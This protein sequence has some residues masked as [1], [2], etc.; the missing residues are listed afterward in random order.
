M[1]FSLFYVL[2]T[3]METIP[4]PQLQLA[5]D[6]V[7]FTGSNIFL[8]GK[9]GTGKTTFLHNLRA[10][11][12]KRLIVVAPTGVAAIN[13]GGVTIHSFFQLPFGP[14]IPSEPTGNDASRETNNPASQH[15]QRFSR[16]KINIIKSLDLLVIDEIS[17]VRADLLDG[18]D[19]V[20]RR[21]KDRYKPFGGVQLLMIGDLQQL[22][23]VI[24]DDEWEILKTYYDTGF[25]F[26]SKA[27]QKTSYVSIELKHIYRQSDSAFIE[28][29]NKVRENNLDA[30]TL[31][32]LNKRHIPDFA[33]SAGE[34]YITLTTHN[35]Q[36]QELNESKLQKLP[37]EPQTFTALVQGEFPEY[38]YP[39]D[40]ELTLKADAQVMFV[41]NDSSREKLYYNGK[42]GKIVSFDDD[43]IYVKCPGEEAEIPVQKAEWQNMKYSID[44][45]T[46]EIQ[47]TVAGSFVQYPL[48][49]AWAITIHKSQ[50]LTFERAI[51]DARSA[52][53]HGQVYVA[54]SRCKTM[55][56]LVLSTPISY[57]SIKSDSTVSQFN[58]NVEENQPTQQKLDDSKYD[59]QQ[60][61]LTELFEFATLQQR[62]NYCL[63]LS[64]EHKASIHLS[65]I[66]AFNRMND[67]LK[68]EMI[69]VS[70]KFKA[71]VQQLVREHHDLEDNEALQDRVKKACIYFADKVETS[72][73]QVIQN[74]SMDIDNKTVRKSIND[75]VNRLREDIVIKLACLKACQNGFVVKDY[76]EARAKS[77]IEKAESR[78]V[79]KTSEELNPD[80]SGKSL[81]YARLKDWREEK[82]DEEDLPLYMI[83]PQ[84]TLMDVIHYMPVSAAELLEIKGFG[85][86]KVKSFGQEII[87]IITEY[88]NEN[89]IEISKERTERLEPIDESG[90]PEK[91][92]KPDTKQT[93]FELFKAGKKVEE[94][95]TERDMAL[96]TIEG[97]LA[98][99]VGT[100][101]LD[102]HQ[103]VSDEKIT[104]ISGYFAR[105][106]GYNLGPAKASLGDNVSWG[107]LR[108]VLKYLEYERAGEKLS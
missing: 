85:K 80:L 79:K 30:Q 24:K 100:G 93:S 31:E 103:F 36:A 92:K 17:M 3:I 62:L 98:H 73:F 101:E 67:A 20:L 81:L 57:Q 83:L 9:A 77:A 27:L 15:I 94:I 55:E 37:V 87:Q 86:K 107:E 105:S 22:A 45:T 29:L 70:G 13:A 4:N 39:T 72:V 1:Y 35:Y 46:K 32:T 52:F 75:A 14:H 26:S 48:K 69:E 99:F 10:R 51:I 89:N 78:P 41:K 66:D 21:Y 90:K 82:A 19:E 16:D 64:N 42:I 104:L 95:A 6:F 88:C 76:L 18:I 49:L 53:A 91:P 12:F 28:L 34:G 97:H 60:M 71:Q 11:S 44:E 50:G 56:G 65:L 59:Y 74:L 43:T 61:L 102:I 25:F 5:Y 106:E 63:K 40:F 54:L 68:S 84:K 33:Q 38:S 58:R 23:P 7:Q 8:T 96:S 47:E 2:N 108:F